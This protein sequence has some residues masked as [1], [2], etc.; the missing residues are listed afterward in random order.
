M[1]TVSLYPSP[2]AAA[3]LPPML[4]AE[5]ARPSAAAARP[6]DEEGNWSLL[7]S[8]SWGVLATLHQGRPYAVPVSY[9]LGADGLYVATGPGRKLQALEAEA[10]VC[11]TV[12]EVI[13]WSR[14]TSVVITADAVPLRGIRERVAALDAIRR[15]RRDGGSASPRD[16][17]R[18]ARASV[19]RLVPLEISGRACP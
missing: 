15:Q 2:L 19:F 13:E 6:L 12:T 11:L 8:H 18:A 5:R 17:A 4:A 10:A 16:V 14:W 1:T 9:G 3:S 7:R